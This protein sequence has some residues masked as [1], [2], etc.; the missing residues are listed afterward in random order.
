[1][2]DRITI[3]VKK[4]TRNQIQDIQDRTNR[5]ASHIIRLALQEYLRRDGLT[6]EPKRS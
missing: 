3:R 6:K 4:E 5:N 1:M 2:S